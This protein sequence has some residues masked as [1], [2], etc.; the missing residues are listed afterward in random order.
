MAV[1]AVGDLQGCLSPLERLL[2]RVR[3]DPVQDRLW[4]VG[5]LVNRGPQSGACLQFVR[6]L[7]ASAIAVLGNHDLHLLA[8]AAGLRVPRARDTLADV[9]RRPDA[10]E[11]LDWL[12]ERPLI[13]RNLELGWTLTHAGIPPQWSVAKACSEARAVEASLRVPA[14]RQEF[15]AS[16]YG[17][18][19]ERW[20]E[21][22]KGPDRL[23]YTVNALTRMRFI[24]QNGA[25]D[26][27]VSGPPVEG[28]AA[29]LKPWFKVSGRASQGHWIAFGHWSALGFRRGPDWLSLDSGCVW[30]RSLTL[31]RLD[32]AGP[33]ASSAW[34][35]PCA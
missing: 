29:G 1:Y 2:D 24:Q 22:L 16:M 31:V 10:D 6:Q 23:R 15:L 35:Q 14:R 26:F 12:A 21:Q 11:L 4:L 9:L 5:D 20:D 3:F 8:T 17:N 32:P 7:G 13:H 27:T 25:L 33:A 28:A 30:G 18:Q 34:H 19:P